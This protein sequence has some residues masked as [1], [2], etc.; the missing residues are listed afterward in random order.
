MTRWPA[1]WRSSAPGAACPACGERAGRSILMGMPSGDVFEALD[2]GEI[3]I[4]TGGC[5]V[6]QKTRRTAARP[7]ANHSAVKPQPRR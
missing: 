6:T 5:C 2:A 1:A 7:A 4:E 3:A